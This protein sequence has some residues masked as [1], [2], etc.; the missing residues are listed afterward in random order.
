MKRN[1]TI[2]YAIIVIAVFAG[3]YLFFAGDDKKAVQ[4]AV[5]AYMAAVKNRNFDVVYAMNASS[6]KRTLFILTG[7]DANKDEL[8]KQYYNEQK[9]AFDSVQAAVNLKDLWAEKAVFAPDMKYRI[10][11]KRICPC[12]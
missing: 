6:Q 10:C 7:S 2:L 1:K 11:E 12:Y 5:D 4:K 9:T 3:V 8:L